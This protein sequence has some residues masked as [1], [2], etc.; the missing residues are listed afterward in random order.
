MNILEA[1]KTR[2]SVRTFNGVPLTAEQCAELRKTIADV[3]DPFGG[4][5]TIQLAEV[6]LDGPYK[7]GT[8]GVI[9]GAS[10]YLLMGIADNPES[11]LAAGFMM[12][13]V[14]L[15]A[16]E[17]GLGT[18]WI[19]ATFKGTDFARLA[20]LESDRPLRIIAPVGTPA[21]HKKFIEKATRFIARSD[22]RKPFE[23]LFFHRNF[24]TPASEN[25]PFHEA[26]EMLRLA[27]S[28]TN[29]QPW[30]AVVDGDKVHFYYADKSKCSILDTGIGICHFTLTEQYLG[31]KGHFAS[32]DHPESARFHY[33][34]TWNP[35]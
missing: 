7:P 26:L 20:K 10:N 5:V 22:K 27:P 24:D 32:A 34:T 12:E 28:S 8:Y 3:I 1:I 4:Q 30:R 29:S 25:G 13:Q 11:Q 15:K 31:H 23:E 14:V 35:D 33:L 16:T 17:M 18:C 19:A 6:K 21:E 2:T 9:T